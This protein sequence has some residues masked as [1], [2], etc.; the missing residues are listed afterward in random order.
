M[1]TSGTEEIHARVISV[2]DFILGAVKDGVVHGQHGCNREN[3]LNAFVSIK[4]RNVNIWLLFTRILK[5]YRLI[6]TQHWRSG[7]SPRL[8][9]LWPGFN[10]QTQQ[11]MGL[12]LLVLYSASRG[13]LRVLRFSPLLKTN[14]PS[15]L[16]SMSPIYMLCPSARRLD[17][18]NK[19]I[20]YYY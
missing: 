18:Q 11:H 15:N 12:S 10:S 19:Y 20:I 4:K 17:T 2:D 6:N 3:L 16:T 7:E 1:V 14:M 9:P 8:L 13:F 5:G